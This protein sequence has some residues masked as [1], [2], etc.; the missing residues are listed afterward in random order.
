VLVKTGWGIDSLSTHRDNRKGIEPDYIADDLID[1]VRW[2][3][4][5]L[6]EIS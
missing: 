6:L 2:I 1:A 3:S 5:D 4:I